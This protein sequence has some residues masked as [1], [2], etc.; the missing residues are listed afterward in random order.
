MILVEHEKSAY[1]VCS[2]KNARHRED[3]TRV[4]T[5]KQSKHEQ[6]EIREKCRVITKPCSINKEATNLY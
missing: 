2:T 4:E 6:G 3:Q 5:K 1:M